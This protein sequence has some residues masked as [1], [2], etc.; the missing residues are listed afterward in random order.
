MGTCISTNTQVV[1]FTN[2]Q[3]QQDDTTNN[4]IDWE[5]ISYKDT[6]QFR[7]EISIA[8]CIKVYV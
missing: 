7:P 6:I 3:T 5:N 1:D 8:K 2:I 4:Q